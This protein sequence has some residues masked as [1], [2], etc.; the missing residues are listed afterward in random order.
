MKMKIGLGQM[1]SGA[2]KAEN[3]QSARTLVASLAE[4]GAELVVLP[5]HSDFIGPDDE[6]RKN[7]EPLS[8]SP[9]LDDMRSLARK[10]EIVLHIGSYLESD[11]EN[12]YNTGV[13][14]SSKGEILATYRKIHLFDV[15]VP[16][17][18]TYLESATITA[19]TDLAV[20][21]AGGITFGMATCYDLRFPELFRRLADMGADVIVLPAAFT[22]QT[23][24]DHWEL[25]LRARAVENQCW[26]IAA[27]QWGSS[28][29]A[30][31]S[32][33][34]SLIADP[35]GTVTAMASDGVTTLLG[36]IDLT[37]TERVRTT[38]P[39]LQHR[40]KDLF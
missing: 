8:N 21:S 6:K 38:F 39:A 40:R 31:I 18:R 7:G 35:W 33:G 11:G 23:G 13:V 22:M 25:L 10:Y 1:N 24:K 15:E 9:F 4:G 19:G 37:I 27:A 29:P 30:N 12:I 14:F 17:G 26:V 20:F 5:E 3:V 28:P 2:D 34:R 16:G 32:Y 36:E